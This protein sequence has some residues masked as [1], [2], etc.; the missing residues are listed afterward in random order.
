MHLQKQDVRS[1][2]R[3]Q[4]NGAS[5]MKAKILTI[6]F[7]FVLIVMGLSIGTGSAQAPPPAAPTAAPADAGAPPP[8]PAAGGEPGT[9]QVENP[10]GLGALLEN[11]D[12]VSHGVLLILSLMS[13]GT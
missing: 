10:Y 8:P 7:A 1:V 9:A 6:A 13:L 12:F 11:G 4:S 5:V 3:K 2:R